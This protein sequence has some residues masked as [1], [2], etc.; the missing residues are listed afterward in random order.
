MRN[1]F[2][3]DIFT[4]REGRNKLKKKTIE[5]REEEGKRIKTKQKL[6]A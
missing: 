2:R 5:Q 1:I 3:N 4:L 6:N